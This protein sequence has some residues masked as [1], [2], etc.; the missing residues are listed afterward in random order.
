RPCCPLTWLAGT[1][2]SSRFAATTSSLLKWDD[3]MLFISCTANLAKNLLPI[4]L[5]D[6]VAQIPFWGAFLICHAFFGH[7]LSTQFFNG[8]LG[9]E[10]GSA[11]M[12][13]YGIHGLKCIVQHQFFYRSV[14]SVAPIA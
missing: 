11:Y 3:T 6:L 4:T 1:R 14:K 8:F 13:V 9:T 10:V 12:E 7:L 5:L 2:Y